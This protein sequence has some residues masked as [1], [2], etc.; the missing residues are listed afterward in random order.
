MLGKSTVMVPTPGPPAASQRALA[1]AGETIDPES[2]TSSRSLSPGPAIPKG[3]TAMAPALPPNN[4]A[5]ISRRR[6]A[7]MALMSAGL[8]HGGAP[9]KKELI[10][11]SRENSGTL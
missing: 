4:A 11:G 10:T 9:T 5:G 7:L 3:I 1:S 2:A 6:E 8:F